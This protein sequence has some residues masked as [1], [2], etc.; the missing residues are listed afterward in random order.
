MYAKEANQQMPADVQS[1][2]HLGNVSAWLHDTKENVERIADKAQA[3]ANDLAG[4][5]P[6]P[7]NT[8]AA[9]PRVVPNGSVARMSDVGMEIDIVLRRLNN[10]LDRIARAIGLEPPN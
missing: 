4:E 10:D 3:I 8:G 9:A 5:Y 6:L 1:T 7:P 2:A